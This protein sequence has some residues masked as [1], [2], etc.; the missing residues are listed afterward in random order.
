MQTD[1]FYC[2]ICGISHCEYTILPSDLFVEDK[3]IRPPRAQ[4]DNTERMQ[5][6]DVQINTTWILPTVNSHPF[7]RLC[8]IKSAYRSSNTH[9][10]THA[11][12]A[13]RHCPVIIGSAIWTPALRLC[14]L[15][16][17]MLCDVMRSDSETFTHTLITRICT[18]SQ[19]DERAHAHALKQV[20]NLH[21]SP[22]LVGARIIKL[23]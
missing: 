5:R 11:H 1:F 6:V 16:A 12:M 18:R 8:N 23:L 14:G 3:T 13:V 10:N 4:W 9:T 21:N 7:R 15:E 2:V 22:G 20:Y 19:A 17:I